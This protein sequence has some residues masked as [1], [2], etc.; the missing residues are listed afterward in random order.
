MADPTPLTAAQARDIVAR[1][2]AM[3]KARWAVIDE[4]RDLRYGRNDVLGTIPAELQSTDFEY[5]GADLDEAILDLTSFLSAADEVWEVDPPRDRDAQKADT[6]ED[7]IA[8]IFGPSG[9]LESEAGDPVADRVWQQQIENGHGIYKLTLKRDYPLA[10]R[11]RF[12]DEPAADM[13]DNPD[14]NRTSRR[15]GR[16]AAGTTR[17]RETDDARDARVSAYMEDEFAWQVRAIDPR[18]YFKVTK[19]GVTVAAG[20]ITTRSV[21]TID[22]DTQMSLDAIADNKIFLSAPAERGGDDT[23]TTFELWTGEQMGSQ[24]F[25]GF[26]SSSADPNGRRRV[27]T[28]RQWTHPYRRP[29]Y[30]EALGLQTTDAGMEYRVVGAFGKMIAELPLLDH[31]ETMHFNSIHRGYFPMYYAVKDPSYGG[32][33]AP[34]ETEQ[35][36]NVTEADAQKQTLPPGWRWETMPS[37]FEPDLGAQLLAARERV[38][39]S[40]ITQVLTGASPGAGDSGA[41]ISLLIN[42]ANRALS[43]FTR[44]HSLARKQM[45]EMLLDVNKRLAIDTYLTVKEAD[46]D[47]NIVERRVTLKA[48][49]IVSCKVRNTLTIKLPVDAAADETRGLTLWQ[50]NAASYRTVAPRFF[51][52]GDPD[53]ERD[54]IAIEKRENQIDDIAFQQASQD[55][56]QRSPSIFAEM[57]GHTE[58]EPPGPPAPDGT[59]GGG[60][61]GTYGGASTM[62]GRGGAALPTA[63]QIDG[64]GAS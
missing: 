32:Q 19:D 40:A 34:L 3:W 12:S 52:V 55:F 44:H 47:G 21:V 31:L 30:F 50:Q 2:E 41:K 26:L 57:M 27:E 14:Y 56:Q 16:E 25:F 6:V 5:H 62:M 7:V 48:S 38:R 42:A 37:G 54:R 53:R 20:E 18:W 35:Y 59:T 1:G 46:D 22:A 58:G 15:A 49:N 61:A 29:P 45:A 64:T 11:R 28:A 13:E 63:T 4:W 33:V 24:G 43:P 17:Y 8:A 51:N 10:L 60:P 23:V 39:Q 36:T 9:M